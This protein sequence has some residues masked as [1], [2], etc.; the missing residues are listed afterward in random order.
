MPKVVIGL[1]GPIS[2]GK[3]IISDYLK[4]LGFT[5]QSLSDRLREEFVRR[6]EQSERFT[7][8]DL[9]NELRRLHGNSVLAE[10]SVAKLAGNEE[11]VVIDSIR[12]TGEIEYLRQ[13]LDIFIVGISAKA[14]DRLSWYLAR[15]KKRGE[16]TATGEAFWAANARDLGEDIE[17][18]QQVSRCLQ[19]ADSILINRGYP[20]TER[21]LIANFRELMVTRFSFD[22]EILRGGRLLERR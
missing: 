4:E 16:D 7:L 2:S 11:Y 5:H 9:G 12:N 17:S 13:T 19:M 18:G 10:M 21:C 6:G 8:Q 1:V 3:G 20:S 15:A 14:E 22:P